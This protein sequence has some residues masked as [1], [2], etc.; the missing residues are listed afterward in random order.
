M[1]SVKLS[2]LKQDEDEIRYPGFFR[3]IYAVRYSETGYSGRRY[4]SPEDVYLDE[5]WLTHNYMCHQWRQTVLRA[6]PGQWFR[7]PLP[8]RTKQTA[9]LCKKDQ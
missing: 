5:S 3:L 7:V 1:T 9:V 8:A 2:A 6:H 4:N